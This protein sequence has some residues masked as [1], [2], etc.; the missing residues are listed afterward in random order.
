MSPA[1]ALCEQ[2]YLGSGQ[3]EMVD[4]KISQDAYMGKM[5]FFFL[6]LIYNNSIKYPLGSVR[7]EQLCVH[8]EKDTRTQSQDT[9]VQV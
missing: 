9:G 1:A 8:I 6:I 4:L 7:Y 5:F 3:S 2:K